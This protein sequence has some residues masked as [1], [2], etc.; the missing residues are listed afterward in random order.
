[1]AF[2][3]P[4]RTTNT[5]MKPAAFDR[6]GGL[7]AEP[8]PSG[9]RPRIAIVGGGAGGLELAIRLSHGL[10]RSRR[11][12]VLLIDEKLTHLWKPLLHELAAG[13]LDERDDVDYLAQA[14]WHGFEFRLGRLTG[15]DREHRRLK[16]AATYSRSGEE[17]VPA[18]ALYYDTLV[19]AVG[20][21]TND[22]GV[23]GAKEH[24]FFLD[25]AVQAE[26]FQDAMLEAYLRAQT[27]ARPLQAGQLTVAIMGGG[28]T[29][30]ELAAELRQVARQFHAYGFNRIDPERDVEIAL[31]QSNERLLPELPPHISATVRMELEQLGVRVFTG[32]RV[33]RVDAAGLA[34]HAGLHITAA[35]KVWAAGIKA[36]EWLRDLDGLEVNRINQLSVR[37]TLQT[38]SDPNVF[39]FGDCAACPQPGNDKPVP[40]RAQAAA[41][42]AQFLAANLPQRLDGRALPSFVYKD[43]GS[44][45][46]LGRAGAV[47]SL[48]GHLVNRL[49][50]HGQ[51]AR[52]MYRLLYKRHQRVLYGTV[53]VAL[54]TVAD[55]LVRP[56]RPR[57][58]L[59]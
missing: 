20:S 16:L 59:H 35:I 26:R 51:L 57:L 46:S 17:V 24:C 47:G 22:L 7:L 31:I 49:A 38:T 52:V 15:I 54:L 56:T 11:A 3:P 37:P 53:R 18:R 27:Q 42:Q 2:V 32:Q 8:R 58:K 41:Q 43:R 12:Q 50:I 40:P 39:A 48:V 45:I 33:T 13:S 30:V 10:G 34:T 21:E 23:A 25:R 28:A 29:G 19:M 36:P 5:A 14:R 6:I 4:A 9:A 1:M 55:W 44:L